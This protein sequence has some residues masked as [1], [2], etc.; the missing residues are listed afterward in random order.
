M[1]AN[2]LSELRSTGEVHRT[3]R[4]SRH[5]SSRGKKDAGKRGNAAAVGLAPG[6][7]RSLHSVHQPHL[8]QHLVQLLYTKHISAIYWTSIALIMRSLESAKNS[9][10]VLKQHDSLQDLKN[11][12]RLQG[13]SS[14]ATDGCRSACWKVFLL[15]DS[16]NT[17]TWLRTLSSSRSAYDSLKTHFL[18]HIDNPDELAATYDPLTE[19]TEVS[20]PSIYPPL[21]DLTGAKT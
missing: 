18:R 15:F 3:R 12:V 1:A 14:I 9:W 5:S 10:E 17:T 7:G 6:S 13:G 2:L 11:A 19:E 16:M 4:R 8:F 21:I 20:S